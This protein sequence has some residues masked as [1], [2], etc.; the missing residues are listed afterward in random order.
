MRD[1][2]RVAHLDRDGV[3][4]VEG[5]HPLLVVAA[6]RMDQGFAQH[7]SGSDPECGSVGSV[8]ESYCGPQ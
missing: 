7:D 3:G 2:G 4:L 5:G 8:G 1:R 6:E